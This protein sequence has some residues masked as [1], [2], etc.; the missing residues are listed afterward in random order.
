MPIQPSSIVAKVLADR[1]YEKRVKPERRQSEADIGSDPT[2][3][4]L[5]ILH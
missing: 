4:D 3:P 2:P 1:P 5:Q